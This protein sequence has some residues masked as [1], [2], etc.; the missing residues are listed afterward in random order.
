MSVVPI[1][2]LLFL[3]KVSFCALI[4]DS[5]HVQLSVHSY[6]MLTNLY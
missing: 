1:Y 3:T 2:F 5:V 6:T 4:L